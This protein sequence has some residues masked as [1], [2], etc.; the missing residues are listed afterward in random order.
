MINNICKNKTIIDK[1]MIGK[2]TDKFGSSNTQN[3]KIPKYQNIKRSKDQNNKQTT[4]QQ[5]FFDKDKR[6]KKLPL[7]ASGA[8]QSKEPIAVVK[9]A[10]FPFL[11]VSFWKERK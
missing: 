11:F 5:L 3:I 6:R 7:K 2:I 4:N 8:S 10:S 9:V 1:L